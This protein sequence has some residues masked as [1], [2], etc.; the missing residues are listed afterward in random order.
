MGG[1]IF[2]AEA[3]MGWYFAFIGGLIGFLI[4]FFVGTLRERKNTTA[5]RAQEGRLENLSARIDDLC[6]NLNV[7]REKDTT[8]D[9][10][11]KEEAKCIVKNRKAKDPKKFAHLNTLPEDMKAVLR[12]FLDLKTT[13]LEVP[14]MFRDEMLVLEKQKAVTLHERPN[15]YRPNQ[16]GSVYCEISPDLL[17]WMQENWNDE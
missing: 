4:N 15:H 13:C 7:P 10:V 9:S 14:M 2:S 5:I 12:L 1:G 16:K 17:A 8:K 11:G 6:R 3:L